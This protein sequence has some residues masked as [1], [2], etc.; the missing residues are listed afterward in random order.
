VI[1]LLRSE[2]G[3]VESTL[4]RCLLEIKL[5]ARESQ[6]K[7]SY[8]LGEIR[9]RTMHLSKISATTESRQELIKSYCERLS[10]N[11]ARWSDASVLLTAY[12]RAAR[13]G[14]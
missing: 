1:P 9:M 12:R 8:V 10:K 6:G 14:S 2:L 11:E 3:E 4:A 7:V 13:W 5:G